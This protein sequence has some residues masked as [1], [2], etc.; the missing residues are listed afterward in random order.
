MKSENGMLWLATLSQDN[1]DNSHPPREKTGTRKP[2]GPSRRNSMFLGSNSRRTGHDCKTDMTEYS[3]RSGCPLNSA[4]R[5]PASPA[6]YKHY[7]LFNLHKYIGTGPAPTKDR[8]K[9]DWG[10][11]RIGNFPSLSTHYCSLQRVNRLNQDSITTRSCQLIR[12]VRAARRDGSA[13]ISKI[14]RQIY[15]QLHKSKSCELR[16]NLGGLA[17]TL[18]PFAERCPYKTIS[19]DFIS[20]HGGA[21]PPN[22]S[23]IRGW[24]QIRM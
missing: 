8:Q 15:I 5:S 22:L 10:S 24:C 2:L 21:K 17:Q 16:L 9:I 18:Q 1:A 12:G 20:N 19:R 6:A 3:M 13:T 23:Q 14:G 11:T 7:A 4:P